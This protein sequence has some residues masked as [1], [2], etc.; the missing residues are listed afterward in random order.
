MSRL[1]TGFSNLFLGNHFRLPLLVAILLFLGSGTKPPYAASAESNNPF[2]EFMSPSGGVN[3]F[4]GDV[5]FSNPLYTLGGINGLKVPLEMNYSGNVHL[6]VR[7]N[8]EKAPTEWAGLGWRLGFGNIRCDHAGTG[9]LADD[10]YYYISPKGVSQE[11]LS[12]GGEYYL[13][14]DPFWK[15]VPTIALDGMRIL[16]W[17]L[18]DVNGKRFKYGD[19]D[20]VVRDQPSASRYVYW[21]KESSP[22]NVNFVGSGFFGT[23]KLYPVQ[24]DLTKEI[25]VDGNVI[26][27]AYTQIRERV[28]QGS[29]TSPI[30]YTQAAYLAS[31]TVSGGGQ[32]LFHTE[33]KSADEY[34]DP[35]TAY[36]EPDAF[37]EF[38]EK[39]YLESIQI[40][41]SEGKSVRTFQ[42][43]YVLK[44]FQGSSL[45][46]Y[47]KRFLAKIK[48]LGGDGNL[49][50][51]HRFT[52]WTENPED[53]RNPLGVLTEMETP[54]CG[55]VKY[56]L[57][58]VAL[59]AA[60]KVYPAGTIGHFEKNAHP[61]GGK[62]KTGEEYLVVINGK[63]AEDKGNELFIFNNEDGVWKQRFA[64]AKPGNLRL[65]LLDGENVKVFPGEGFFLVLKERSNDIFSINIFTWDGKDW[66]LAPLTPD[67]KTGWGK[68][69]VLIQRD[70]IVVASID[71]AT[72]TRPIKTYANSFSLNGYSWQKTLALEYDG[73][74]SVQL[75]GVHLLFETDVGV[76]L[77]YVWNGSAWVFAKKVDGWLRA[78]GGLGE[79]LVYRFESGGVAPAMSALKGLI[80]SGNSWKDVAKK[81]FDAEIYMSDKD[82]PDIQGIGKDYVLARSDDKDHLH[83][84]EFTGEKFRNTLNRNMVNSDWDTYNEAYWDGQA[85]DD[86]FV[87]RYPRIKWHWHWY[88]I[89]PYKEIDENAKLIA[90]NRVGNSWKE[91]D[92]GALDAP[93]TSKSVVLGQDFFVHNHFPYNAQIWDGANWNVS[94]RDLPFKKN[95]IS[96]LSSTLAGEMVDGEIALF[97]KF[98][99]SLIAPVYAYVVSKKTVYDPIRG[100]TSKFMYEYDLTTARF[101]I[102]AASAKFHKVTAVL[103]DH[104]RTVSWFHNG[105]QD[106]A[107]PMSLT[108]DSRDLSGNAYLE[109]DLDFSGKVVRENKRYFEVVR[110]DGVWPSETKTIRIAKVESINNKV[111]SLSEFT[112][113]ETN[114]LPKVTVQT[115][116][117]GRK[118][119][120]ESIF[121]FNLPAYSEMGLT[122]KHMLSQVAETHLYEGV[123][124]PSQIKSS[125]ISTWSKDT[126]GSWH[127]FQSWVWN[128]KSDGT[129]AYIAFNHL[130][131][132]GNAVP[133]KKQNTITRRDGLGR[134]L[135]TKAANM[136]SSCFLY[137]REGRH[138]IA[139]IAN[140]TCGEVGILPGDFD[141]ADPDFVDVRNGW[142]QNN[143]T[144][145]RT[146]NRFGSAAL[147]VPPGG[148]GPSKLLN[149]TAA[150]KDY[151]FSAWIYPISLSSSGPI[152]LTVSGPSGEILPGEAAFTDLKPGSTHGWQRVERKIPAGLLSGAFANIGAEARGGAEFLIQDIRFLPAKSQAS[153]Q[154]LD[155]RF[156][157]PLAS[158]SPTGSAKYFEYDGIGRLTK[159]YQEDGQGTKV[160]R[161]ET[162]FHLDGCSILQGVTGNLAQLKVSAGW[163]SFD[164]SV[165]SY[166]ELWVDPLT[167]RVT[168]DF[169]PEN[170]NED[171][172]IRIAGGDWLNPCCQGNNSQEIVLPT[173]TTTV[174]IRVGAGIPY[175][176]PYTF[177]IKKPST[178][179]TPLGQSVSGGWATLPSAHQDGSEKYIAYT[180]DQDGGKLYVKRWS[181]T[182]QAWMPMGVAL[183]T[184]AAAEITL[185]V[186]GGVPYVAYLDEI[187]SPQPTG[188]PIVILKA[189]VKKWNGSAW[190]PL[191]GD[192]TVS[193]GTA[194]SLA[195]DVKGTE[196]WVAY[197]GIKAAEEGGTLPGSPIYVRKWNGTAWIL[198]GG[199]SPANGLVSD[200]DGEHVTLAIHPDGTPYVGYIGRAR[201]PAGGDQTAGE[202][203][204]PF[205]IVKKLI[206]GSGGDHWGDLVAGTGGAYGMQGE[207]L[208]VPAADRVQVAFAGTDLY[209]AL[210]YAYLA[211][212]PDG[213]GDFE[214]TG[215]RV[216]DVRKLRPSET[217]VDRSHWFPLTSGTTPEDFAVTPLDSKGDFQFSASG[218][219]PSLV[220]VNQHNNQKITVLN[221]VS[222]MWKAVGSPAF[223][224]SDLMGGPGRVSL[225][226]S[227]TG[228]P[229]ISARQLD[230]SQESTRHVLRALEY[231]G[232]CPDLTLAQLNVKEGTQPIYLDWKF[233]PFLLYLEGK[234]RSEATTVN[235]SVVPASLASLSKVIIIAADGTAQEWPSGSGNPLPSSF[236]VPLSAGSN[237]IQV[238]TVSGDGH[239]RLRYQVSLSRLPATVLTGTVKLGGFVISPGFD[240]EKPR[241]YKI[242]VPI[243]KPS[244]QLDLDISR[245]ATV[246]I[247][248]NVV[249]NQDKVVVNLVTGTTVI[250]MVL[251]MEDG[252]RREFEFQV[253]RGT[254]SLPL[255]PILTS[256]LNN[257]DGS[258]TAHFGYENENAMER[259][260]PIGSFNQ[261]RYQGEQRL[262]MG[263]PT[264]FAP[265]VVTNAFA[266]VFDGSPLNWDLD[267][268][269]VTATG[270]TAMAALK[271][272]MKDNG[273][274]E[275]N[276][277]KPQLR[278]VN[279]STS[280]FSGFKISLWL[281][282]EEVP[283]QEI[284]ADPYYFNPSGV[285]L[286]VHSH[287]N[288]ENLIRV[289]LQY[290]SGFTLPPGAIT[291]IDGAQLGIHFRNYYPG[292]WRRDNDWSW[293]GITAVYKE[294]P[295]VTVY[296]S[297][298]GLIAGQEPIVT[299]IPQPPTL[300]QA[301]VFSMESLW[302]WQSPTIGLAPSTSLKTEGSGGLRAEGSGYFKV[303]SSPMK[304]TNIANETSKMRVDFY[305][306]PDQ[307]NPYWKGA[308]QLVVNSPSA[309]LNGFYVGQVELTP[310]T[311]G[312]FTALEFIL[313]TD[314]VNI[315]KGD[316][317]DF[318]FEWVLNIN[319][320]T[321]K[322]VLDNMRFVP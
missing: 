224:T 151:L 281:S 248:G 271:V 179:W 33:N 161:S 66:K 190:L 262:D 322:P 309:G 78:A 226:M 29:W 303:L 221:F 176:T 83:L 50:G 129:E 34:M 206:S 314:V 103:P 124:N 311:S 253:D 59:G 260:I 89:V 119:I 222:G 155:D 54:F 36:P 185:R 37:M 173:A 135:E 152:A 255:R 261:I 252:T 264:R 258:F 94:N 42:F 105:E 79:N 53:V 305:L 209:L 112:F 232:S 45:P 18:T 158:A 162:E 133:W 7:A 247:D 77:L 20:E 205:P 292:A 198:V 49:A 313:P 115:G 180:A 181:Q 225:S 116:S 295:Y 71:K 216:L 288:N 192:G 171:V 15:V 211:P 249:D 193:L 109:Q 99:N 76:A 4:S 75:S 65:G 95:S 194:R 52:Y 291:D 308:L 90:F 163:L 251:V 235:L 202:Y 150:G 31:I 215:N 24:W 246:F 282:R 156:F 98:Q 55:T 32:I 27:Y 164:K 157:L 25:D 189:V 315:L 123:A 187:L 170:P 74:G 245:N 272:M 12:K 6:N 67:E 184:G 159:F 256:V 30:E 318:Q 117:A 321:E 317:R 236:S 300:T 218:S 177:T 178:C 175:G 61:V 196:L 223:L 273:L 289:D 93:N 68:A 240:I 154:F 160:L 266:V 219:V 141:D 239:G 242:L 84:L 297:D 19:S 134:V 168:I 197:K 56:D 16:A 312:V 284:L 268:R 138:A 10:R 132:T 5:A 100:Q 294:T 145:N 47:T 51:S 208:N 137:G 304:T 17:T 131:P 310:L 73:S 80:W 40:T 140:A 64:D 113:D 9:V 250:H 44:N 81:S 290:P 243:D 69:S 41:S 144:L 274:A 106:A 276:I 128:G 149:A 254:P 302:A 48:E 231:S 72:P 108:P 182:G 127:A 275:P 85:R 86:Y 1:N 102:R 107:D 207:V 114:G 130:I 88:S 285:T 87:V 120:E 213:S 60:R 186:S 43:E 269:T 14:K 122:G 172:Q 257:P 319:L 212:I 191:V 22:L 91:R 199:S 70:M 28:K 169:T 3:L 97:R 306:P 126:K 35:H 270:Y 147:Q 125:Q 13:S 293:Q 62:L 237:V 287:P 21:W 296:G 142:A 233:R 214:Q 58:R 8:N 210:A 2:N 241:E 110:K 280:T 278:L 121:A 23:P 92:F 279:A 111:R 230:E 183:S 201:I 238:E 234:I 63:E 26:E 46:G 229:L 166:G 57:D 244:L 11:I 307:P 263:Q 265:A 227:G 301:A 165:R 259:A 277:S 118:R 38:F 286:A 203:T 139:D 204:A 228:T 101:E 136:S 195:F 174:E 167:D 146:N 153:V 267:G 148:H 298:G 96:L 200:G 283:S 143:T 320:T 217:F 316:Y 82:M 220:F 39:Q 104:G 299:G 188:D